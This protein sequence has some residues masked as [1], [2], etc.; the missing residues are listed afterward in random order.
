MDE[1]HYPSHCASFSELVEYPGLW[2]DLDWN[3]YLEEELCRAGREPIDS[4]LVHVIFSVLFFSEA[5]EA[6]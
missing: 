5:E 3:Q 2:G 4:H 1:V 6:Y